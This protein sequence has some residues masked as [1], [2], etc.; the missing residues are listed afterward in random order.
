MS[1]DVHLGPQIFSIA[2]CKIGDI[3]EHFCRDKHFLPAHVLL[4]VIHETK[5]CF[6]IICWANN[7]V[8]SSL[9]LGFQ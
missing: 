6:Y 3:N 7:I 1:L 4:Q 9:G 5:H 8:V 2:K